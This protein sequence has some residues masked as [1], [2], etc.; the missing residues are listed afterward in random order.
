LILSPIRPPQRPGW[1]GHDLVRAL[2]QRHDGPL[3]RL[4]LL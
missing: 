1:I 4:S 3:D 2:G